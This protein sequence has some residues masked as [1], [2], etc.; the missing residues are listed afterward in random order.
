MT[1]AVV[2][3]AQY[4]KE[5][6]VIDVWR[7]VSRQPLALEIQHDGPGPHVIPRHWQK[8]MDS[9]QEL[10]RLKGSSFI[11]DLNARKAS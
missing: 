6:Q 8:W 4:S 10:K 11:W 3:E 2:L 5:A 9:F 7:N 1:E